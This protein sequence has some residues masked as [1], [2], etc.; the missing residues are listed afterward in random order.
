MFD[1]YISGA[2]YGCRA[3]LIIWRT[4]GCLPS[5]RYFERATSMILSTKVVKLIASMAISSAVW[6]F[7]TI[8]SF[9]GVISALCRYRN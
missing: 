9:C 5:A 1:N 6:M 7:I 8:T 3:S 4:G 2:L